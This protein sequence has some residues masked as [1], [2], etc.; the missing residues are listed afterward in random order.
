ME[1]KRTFVQEAGALRLLGD[2]ESYR[3]TRYPEVTFA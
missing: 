2:S 3:V 1:T